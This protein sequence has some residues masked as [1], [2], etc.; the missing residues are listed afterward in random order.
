MRKVSSLLLSLSAAELY[1][2]AEM[3]LIVGA[4]ARPE[5]VIACFF[6]LEVGLKHWV[7]NRER[8]LF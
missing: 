8:E 1:V 7:L 5:V 2:Y 3:R 4:K 6:I